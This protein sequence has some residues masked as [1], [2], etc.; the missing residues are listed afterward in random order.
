LY[1]FTPPTP[2][3]WEVDLRIVR[4]LDDPRSCSNSDGKVVIETGYKYF[5]HSLCKPTDTPPSVFG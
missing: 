1:S 3:P 5:A 4:K 2:S